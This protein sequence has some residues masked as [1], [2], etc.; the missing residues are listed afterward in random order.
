MASEPLEQYND[1]L[2]FAS[3]FVP[4]SKLLGLL[5][6]IILDGQNVWCR[7]PGNNFSDMGFAPPGA[8]GAAIAPAMVS[9]NLIA[10][11]V[12]G[13]SVVRHSNTTWFEGPTGPF[14]EG[15]NLLGVSNGILMLMVSGVATPA[16]LLKPGAPT[17]D[18]NGPATDKFKGSYS[19]AVAAYRQTTG[20]VS[21][22]SDL[23]NVIFTKNTQGRIIA[24]GSLDPGAT[25]VLLYGTLR[26]FGSLGP[27]FRVVPIA[28]IPRATYLNAAASPINFAFTDGDLGDLAFLANDPPLPGTACVG[29]GGS[30]VDLGP[31]GGY[32]I[33]PS[34]LSFSE[35]FD[36]NKISFLAAAEQISGIQPYGAEGIVYVSTPNS[37]NVL[38]LTGS[39]VTPILPRGLWPSAGFSGPNSWCL[40]TH[41]IYGMP[42]KGGPVRTQGS[43]APDFSFGYP[44]STYMQAHN[45]TSANTVV[46]HCPDKNCVI[47]ASGNL[48]LPFMLD[49]E[50]WSTPIVL[51]GVVTA[52]VTVGQTGFL[53]V[54]T[55]TYQ[56]DS[57]NGVG[58]TWFMKSEYHRGKPHHPLYGQSHYQMKKWTRHLMVAASDA[59]TYSVVKDMTDTPTSPLYPWNSG[60]GGNVTQVPVPCGPCRSYALRVSG[61]GG[62]QRFDSAEL[63]VEVDPNPS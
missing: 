17:I 29:M 13:G 60:A 53:L 5:P 52:G 37:L 42:N 1:V 2:E 27:A 31:L 6:A 49:S 12:G 48:A 55:A 16:G 20:A 57:G 63:I 56:M 21:T 43:M 28:A 54:G 32:G 25:H 11:G 61:V 33:S 44:V 50:H 34:N 3:S 46:I 36:V 58:V 22:R 51:P 47:F 7:G 30:M 4:N 40:V 35:A 41:A 23:S 24:P 39:D 19:I 26:G 38:V 18:G 15:A 45:F 10:G 62:G 14:Y 59:M 8:V 9:F